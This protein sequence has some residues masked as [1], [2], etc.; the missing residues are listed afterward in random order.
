ML[1]KKISALTG[2]C[3]QSC[4]VSRGIQVLASAKSKMAPNPRPK[5]RGFLRLNKL[6]K[7]DSY[8]DKIG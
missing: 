7:L 6:K 4:H 3:G 8:T 2:K 1:W 5:G